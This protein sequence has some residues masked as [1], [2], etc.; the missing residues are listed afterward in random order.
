[1]AAFLLGEPLA[2]RLQQLFEAAHRLDLFL[3]FLGEIFFRELLEPLDRDFRRERL[4]DEIEAFEHVAEHAI[5]LVEIAL[6]LHQRRARQI[7]EILD[8]AAARSFSI[9][10]ISV[11]YSRS[12]TGTPAA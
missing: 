6:V 8:P 10:S 1:M 11:R 4:L 7:V 12:V 3:F 2:Q 5:E 9:A